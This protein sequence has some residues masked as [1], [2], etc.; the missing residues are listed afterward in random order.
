[1]YC[2]AATLLPKT[3]LFTQHS[4]TKTQAMFKRLLPSGWFCPQPYLKLLVAV[5]VIAPIMVTSLQSIKADPVSAPLAKRGDSAQLTEG[6]VAPPITTVPA[7]VAQ[8]DPIGSPHPIPWN[9]VMTTHV[10]V[11]S[12]SD[13]RLHYYRSPSLVSPNGKYAA[14]SR[15]QMD[16]QPELYRSRVSSV[17]FVEDLQTRELQVIKATSP[18]GN[19]SLVAAANAVPGAISILTPVSWSKTSDRLLA[20]Q[21]EGLFSSSDASDFAVIWYQQQNRT[22]TVA[23]SQAQYNHEISILLGWSQIDPDQ[24]IFR[25][26]NLGDEQWPLWAVAGNGQTVAAT[27]VDQPMVFGKLLNQVWSGPQVASR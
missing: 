13:S 6:I 18:L 23:P 24:V 17:M 19:N 20:R 5:L 4:P 3:L 14:Y 26:G 22:S 1:M 11:S 21:F 15:I 10:D 16:V 25:A 7:T 8:S 27:D 12:K 9:W 2:Q